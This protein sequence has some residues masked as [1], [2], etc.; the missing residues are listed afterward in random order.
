NLFACKFDDLKMQQAFLRVIEN[1]VQALRSGQ[2]RIVLQSRNVE[3]KEPTQDR[4]VKLAT[5]RY[6]CVEISDNGCGIEADVLPR[7]FEPFFTTK[8][9]K[10]HRGIGLAWVYGIVTNLGGGVAVSSRP[11]EGTS[12]RVYL[13]AGK[14]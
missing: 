9:D 12:V 6:V 4:N 1:S 3:L 2:G 7:I 13:P 5:G 11:G 8:R 14:R 10:K